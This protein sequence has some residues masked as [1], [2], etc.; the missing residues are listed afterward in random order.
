MS[1][2]GQKALALAAVAAL[3]AGC[4]QEGE[5]NRVATG[6]M[7]GGNVA[8]GEVPETTIGETLA[9][10]A[11]HSTLASAVKAAGL[12][13][14]L[15]GS[16]PYTLFAPT[17]A[18]FG[19]LPDGAA[20]GLMQPDQKGQLT[21]VITYHIVPG[22]VL[23]RDL[24]AAIERGDGRTEL[25]TVGGGTITITKDGDAIIVSDGG[26]QARVTQADMLQSNGV[27]HSI[28]AVLMP[29]APAPAAGQ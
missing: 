16:Q 20:E 9:G 12:E 25:A 28:D 17:N 8:A 26:G 23:A 18:A 27:V 4:Q 24:D 22:V 11:D 14:T 13:A 10:S 3:A 29:A 7:A 19:K 1:N 6:N 15:A 21:S 5:A 2:M